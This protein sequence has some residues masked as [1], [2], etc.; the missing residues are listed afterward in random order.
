MVNK[1]AKYVKLYDYTGT[2]PHNVF[3]FMFKTHE[4]IMSL[5]V[6]C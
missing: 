2:N 1:D 3:I 6:H 4:K 5:M